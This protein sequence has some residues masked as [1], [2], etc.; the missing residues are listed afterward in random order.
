MIAVE[1][2]HGFQYKHIF[3]ENILRT[4][5]DRKLDSI[6]IAPKSEAAAQMDGNYR[7]LLLCYFKMRAIL[8]GVL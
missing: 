4:L 2:T 3:N 7:A 1:F 6:I 5:L 8:A